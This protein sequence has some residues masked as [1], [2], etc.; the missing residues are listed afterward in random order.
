MKKTKS[1]LSKIIIMVFILIGVT[2]S[3][4]WADTPISVQYFYSETCVSC[5]EISKMLNSYNDDFNVKYIN[6]RESKEY[7]EN[8]V[9]ENDLVRK[10]PMIKT[11][12]QI[13]VGYEESYNFLT[14][15][16]VEKQ[17]IKLD[18]VAIAFAGLI[19]GINPCAIS[20]LLILL[21]L[22][23]N[24]AKHKQI[25]LVGIIFS[26]TTFIV[27]F[28][29]G[30]GMLKSLIYFSALDSIAKFLY[31]IIGV[32]CL[33]MAFISIQDYKYVKK[34]KLEKVKTQL[35]KKYRHKAMSC[36]RK[37]FDSNKVYVSTFAVAV[38]VSLIDFLCTGGIYLPS[39]TYMLSNKPGN[40]TLAFYL[41][42]Y[43]FMFI[44]PILAT[45]V[46]VSYSK[47]ILDASEILT[48]NLGKIKILG[49]S[50]YTFV[51]IYMFKIIF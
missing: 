45:T 31:L 27:Y 41:L 34:D 46:L 50:F 26:T 32:F 35:N 25:L 38:I 18:F 28:L 39:I 1:P 51:A 17:N 11:N 33:Y 15:K 22:L 13:Y 21:S 29:I 6:I 43:N 14:N 2:T 9:N 42:T 23:L 48:K 3:F 8:F 24:T 49:F 10:V 4:C 37:Y 19:D 36:I 5:K 40:L 44:L 47:N 30:I 16:D 20:M 7:F 12:E